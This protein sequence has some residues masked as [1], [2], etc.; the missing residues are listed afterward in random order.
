MKKWPAPVPKLLEGKLQPPELIATAS[1]SVEKCEAD[2]YVG[3]F[4][5]VSNR[6]ADAMGWYRA[7]TESCPVTFVE[8]AEARL[9]M[10]QLG[11]VP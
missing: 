1:G 4:D 5:Q 2:F 3:A 10:K 7:A 8:Y 9:A 6:T 11:A